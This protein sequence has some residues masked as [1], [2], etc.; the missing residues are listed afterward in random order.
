LTGKGRKNIPATWGKGSA[1]EPRVAKNPTRKETPREIR[2]NK[3]EGTTRAQPDALVN[4]GIKQRG[5]GE[6]LI[7]KN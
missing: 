7:Q 3:N 5:Q 1:P 4:R 2:R 6:Q